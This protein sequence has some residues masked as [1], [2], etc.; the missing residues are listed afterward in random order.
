MELKQSP[1]MIMRALRTLNVVS[2][3]NHLVKSIVLFSESVNI[4][5]A[6]AAILNFS[7]IILQNHALTAVQ[8]STRKTELTT[9]S[10]CA[11]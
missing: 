6:K 5:S 8:S 4:Q 2:V 9:M 3:W 11:K 10:S 1:K 7:R